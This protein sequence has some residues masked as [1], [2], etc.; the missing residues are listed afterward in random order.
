MM[1]IVLDLYEKRLK[2]LKK[3]HEIS[4]KIKSEIEKNR[5]ESV[6]SIVELTAKRD[7]CLEEIKNF[8]LSIQYYIS[9]LPGREQKMIKTLKEAVTKNT[10]NKPEMDISELSESESE[11]DSD[12]IWTCE[13]HSIFADSKTI[14]DSIKSI[15]EN[16]FDMIKSLL[17]E[18]KSKIKAV[19]GNRILMNKY[20]GDTNIY[21]VGTLMNQR[22]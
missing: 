1:K 22:K 6:E 14:L 8:D 17:A 21:S 2:I 13:L 15:D 9:Q 12:A 11:S 18:L 19:K 3:Y 5:D 10:Q 16:N 4:I 7:D 20:T